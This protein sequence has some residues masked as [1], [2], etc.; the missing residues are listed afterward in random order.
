MSDLILHHY[1]GSPFSE[2]VRLVLGYKRLAWQSVM[3]PVV[4]PK[5]DVVALTGGYRRTPF[6]QIGA[7][8]YCDSAL[9]CRVIDRLAPQ[10]ALYPASATG[11]QHALAQWADAFLFWCAVP[12]TMQPAG[13]PHIFGG[14]PPAFPKAFGADRLEMTG[15]T[16][17]VTIADAGVQLAAYCE[18]IESLLGDER[19]FLLG[20]E[21]CI[22]DF[23]VGQSIWFVLRAP[24]V[25]V[26]LE[27]YPKLLA[28]YRRVAEFGHGTSTRLSSADAI[29]IAKRATDHAP[30]RVEPGLGFDAG[31]EVT[32]NATDYGTDPV[33]GTL[34]GL[35][36]DEVVVARTDERAGTL[37]V[38]FP[39][40]GF[41]VKRVKQ[42]TRS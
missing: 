22:A 34:V 42:E 32:V 31:A 4:M 14:A 38:H 7:D 1:L 24:P 13:I 20:S 33:A 26:A 5:P 6:M 8:V 27:P 2:K 30:V 21:P 35:T 15:G 36:K 3:V 29:D 28:W 19:T 17:R 16:R 25:A 41:Q 39:R 40:I 12:F 23:S 37:H 10:P 11:L 9:M 18:W